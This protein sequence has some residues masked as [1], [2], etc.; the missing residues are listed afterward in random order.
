MSIWQ[1]VKDFWIRSYT[2]D[3]KAFYYETVASACVFVSMTWISITAYHP[4]MHLIYPISF[5]GAVFSIL[6]FIRR[7]AGWPLVMTCYFS[8]LHVF[9]FGRAMGWY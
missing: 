4:P 8:F 1:K 2:S 7:G 6:A 5:F 9:G 3:R